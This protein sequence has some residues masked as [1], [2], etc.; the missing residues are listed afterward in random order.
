MA[1]KNNIERYST[2]GEHKSAV[3][4]RFNRTL[5]EN[6]WK[7]FTA[8][9]TRNWISMLDK[10]MS[11]Y[12]NRYH[13]TIKMTP[14]EASMKENEVEGLNSIGIAVNPIKNTNFMLVIKFISVD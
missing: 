1:E 9:N 10:L 7:M 13:K 12:N 8:K 11:D 3:V 14:V 4:E 5:K 2:H 6:M